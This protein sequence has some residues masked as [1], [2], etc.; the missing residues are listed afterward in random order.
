MALH[1]FCWQE[2]RV[3]AP[4]G[5]EKDRRC[6]L[7]GAN[8]FPARNEVELDMSAILQWVEDEIQ[9]LVHSEMRGE[10]QSLEHKADKNTYASGLSKGMAIADK[11]MIYRLL[12]LRSLIRS[13]EEKRQ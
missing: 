5:G 8:H 1:L 2:G 3:L 11:Q 4:H 9:S 13:I 12:A 10:L 7:W 6:R